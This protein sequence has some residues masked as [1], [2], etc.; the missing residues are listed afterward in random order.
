MKNTKRAVSLLLAA[1][2]MAGF[3]LTGCS[4]TEDKKPAEDTP[5]TPGTTTEDKKDSEPATAE[6]KKEDFVVA[7][8]SDLKTLDPHETNDSASSLIY[9]HLY[10][11]LTQ[12]DE[13]GNI[14]GDLA[15]SW[16]KSDDELTWTFKLRQGVKFH[17]GSEFKASD[18][19]FSIEREKN[20][21]RNA[22]MVE[23]IQEVVVDNDYQVTFKMAEPDGS[24][25]YNLAQGGSSMFSE[26][27]VTAAGDKYAENPIGT[28]PMKYVE[29]VPN[30]HITLERFDDYYA[31]A[32]ASKTVTFR[33][34]PEGSSR[35]I[36]LEN[37]EVDVVGGVVA[38]DVSK[39]V[40]NPNLEHQMVTNTG[41]EYLGF[42][43]EREPFKDVRVRQAIAYAINKED[44]VNVVLEG[45]GVVSNTVVGRPIPGCDTTVEGYPYNPEKA[46]ELLAE[47]GFPDGFKT[48]IKTS[49]D[50]RNQEAVLIQANLA[51][52][53][54]EAE[55]ILL[56]WG[57]YLESINGGDMDTYIISWGNPTMDPAESLNPLFNTKNWGP[58]GN[59]MH[60]SNAE[61]DALLNEL[62]AV[63]DMDRRLE[64]SS[65]IQHK[66]VADAPWATLFCK[67]NCLAYRK[68]LKGL[69]VMPNDVHLYYNMSY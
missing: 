6:N 11:C 57:A 9:A 33:V 49:G 2:M 4:S 20:S 69:K 15:E 65:E 14:I 42:N 58:T 44:I 61:V 18:V 28:G 39:V 36:A 54:I 51:E 7:V 67:N 10:S 66:V 30:D 47:A 34:I 21:A 55:I 41:V 59:R 13:S 27:A 1:A 56:D 37:G 17:D 24:L 64:L 40:E 25:L 8:S 60:Y 26:A 46:K 52:V 12:L 50:T 16:E 53:G 35:T 3:A 63:S 38:I 31:G 19:K 48:T 22:Y 43:F 29:W 32:Q 23:K 45:N 62:M 68:G 5:S